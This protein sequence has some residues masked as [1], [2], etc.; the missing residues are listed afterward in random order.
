M[1]TARGLGLSTTK[2]VVTYGVA[3]LGFAASGVVTHAYVDNLGPGAVQVFA[4]Q[5]ASGA[6]ID[7]VGA[8]QTKLVILGNALG[9]TFV[10]PPIVA[11][12]PLW[13]N[14]PTV[15]ANCLFCDANELAG[16]PDRRRGATIAGLFNS[17]CSIVAE[18]LGFDRIRGVTVNL[19]SSA[20][21]VAQF[22]L[23]DGQCVL[24]ALEVDDTADEA[25]KT[26]S[27][28]WSQLELNI[29]PPDEVLITLSDE[30]LQAQDPID[31]L[32]AGA[33]PIFAD[34]DEV[35]STSTLYTVPAGQTLFIT[36]AWISYIAAAAVGNRMMLKAGGAIFLELPQAPSTIAPSFL[37]PIVVRSG[38][39]VV[40]DGTGGAWSAGGASAG[41]AGYLR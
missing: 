20:A 9:V 8:G 37:T 14:A 27:G 5:N 1:L 29:D 18:R 35:G 34:V 17:P 7:V 13:P 30:P 15:S 3:D 33:N 16:V 21:G 39:Q 19:L 6:P 26:V 40:L 10:L 24:F 11:E 2:N 31:G 38:Q 28:N 4:G 36:S 12:G 22:S 32:P 25:I 41:F 23:G